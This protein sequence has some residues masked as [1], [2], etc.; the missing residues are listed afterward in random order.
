MPQ[1]VG[2]ASDPY[3]S[4]EPCLALASQQGELPLGHHQPDTQD[5]LGPWDRFL[6][7]E[8][9]CE[10]QIIS[11]TFPE[12]RRSCGELSLSPRTAVGFQEM[13][14][15]SA[16]IW[17]MGRNLITSNILSGSSKAPLGTRGRNRISTTQIH[18]G[19]CSLYWVMDSKTRSIGQLIL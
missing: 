7:G 15:R 19:L 17:R 1:V 16:H 2:L 4:L 14:L 13:Q 18:K 3:P 5:S 12:Q 9:R 10:L 8:P 6:P 11:Q